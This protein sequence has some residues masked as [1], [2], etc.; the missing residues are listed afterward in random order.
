MNFIMDHQALPTFRLSVGNTVVLSSCQNEA[1][2]H[3][4]I[5]LTTVSLG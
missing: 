2:F 1:L 3:E 4:Y 5:L